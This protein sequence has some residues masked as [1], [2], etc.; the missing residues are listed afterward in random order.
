MKKIIISCFAFLLGL[1]LV[2]ILGKAYASVSGYEVW[3]SD[4]GNTQGITATT[5]N[6]QYGGKVRIYD[7]ADLENNPPVNNPLVLDVATDLFPNALATTGDNVN[8]IHIMYP[9][10]DYKYMTLNFVASG[11]L[12]IVD[13]KTKQPVCL[14]RTTQ[15]STGRQ[16]HMSSVSPDGTKIILANQAGRML[17]RVDIQKDAH[18]QTTGFNYNAD[19]SIDLVGGSGRILAQPIAVDVNRNDNISCT[20]T[21]TVADGQPTTTPNGNLKQAAGVRPTN[22]VICPIISDN[23]KHT[24]ATI[25]GGGMFVVDITTSP[26]QIVAEYD[27]S[28]V[29][30]AGCG[31][32]SAN[33]FMMLN[34]GTSAPNVSEFTVYRFTQDYPLAPNFNHP[35]QPL[36]IAVWADPENGNI[37]PGNNRDAHG[38]VVVRNFKSRKDKYLHQFDRVRNNVEVF[39]M[40]P[41]W[42][43]LGF[44]REGTYSL[45]TTGACG[46]TLGAMHGND[47]TPDLADI[48]LGNNGDRIYVALR[49]PLPQSIAHAAAGS[50]PGL[51]IVTLSRH[52]NS[53]RLT[54]VLPTMIINGDNSKNLSDPHAAIVR[55]KLNH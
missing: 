30:A 44:R 21:G 48:S 20:L 18:G 42:D 43:N 11:H 24:Y 6:G 45:T 49:G 35:N 15:T 50:C 1:S 19:A 27:L 41:P 26:M 29:R 55:Q 33:G 47:P 13:G 16:N 31:G 3:L 10:P 4:Q 2:L 39:K 23:S 46:Q 12:G 54:H 40:A 9:T 7:S 51:G 52:K 28:V 14:F 37:I 32:Q 17:E 53:G 36:P 38:M 5:P 25:G 22:T 8:R 34:T